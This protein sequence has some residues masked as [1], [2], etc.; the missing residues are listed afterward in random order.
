MFHHVINYQ[1]VSIPFAIIGVSV[2]GVDLQE[3]KEYNNLRHGISG[4]LKF[5][6][7]VSN[8]EYFNLFLLLF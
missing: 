7:N 1:H 3:Y 4:T 2:I 8:I 5:I 6:I